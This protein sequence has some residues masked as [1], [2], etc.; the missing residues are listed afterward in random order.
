M[1][2]VDDYLAGLDEGS[3]DAFGQVLA[4]ALELVPDAEQGTGYGMPALRYRGRPLLGFRAAQAHLSVF[5][6]SATAVETA[7]PQLAG[8][9]LTK[10]T[11]RFSAA[12]P[13]PRQAVAALVRARMVEIGD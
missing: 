6:F 10:G 1:G 9:D 12:K 2:T 7:A 3:R 8:F 4:A 5:P 13:L 11:V